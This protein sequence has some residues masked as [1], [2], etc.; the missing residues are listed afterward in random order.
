MDRR[1][2]NTII[3]SLCC[4]T[5]TEVADGARYVSQSH[6]TGTRPTSSCAIL[7][8]Q[9]AL[10]VSRYSKMFEVT[11]ITNVENQSRFFSK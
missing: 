6:Y 10:W 4:H 11:D 8:T 9:G 5:G 1:S 7:T 3:I 2:R